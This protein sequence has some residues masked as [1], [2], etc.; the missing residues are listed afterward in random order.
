MK[1][2]S[3]RVVDGSIDRSLR[4]A[5]GSPQR[6]VACASSI[7]SR[8]FTA[9]HWLIDLL[10]L[11]L[12]ALLVGGAALYGLALVSRGMARP[13]PPAADHV[14]RDGL[15]A[16]PVAAGAWADLLCCHETQ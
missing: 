1:P 15:E 2:S 8:K 6:A 14:I 9:D 11:A 10:A 5:A 13:H 12:A 7:A 3:P 16:T 4:S